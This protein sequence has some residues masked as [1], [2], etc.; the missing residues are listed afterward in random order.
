MR[1]SSPRGNQK[2][3]DHRDDH[4]GGRSGLRLRGHAAE[5]SWVTARGTPGS[6]VLAGRGGDARMTATAFISSTSLDLSE[7]RKAAI[8][9]CNELGIVPS[10]M[11]FFG[12]A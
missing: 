7:Y 9:A 10:A 11:E 12:A 4:G 3:D 1:L 2:P 8:D 6:E 5:V